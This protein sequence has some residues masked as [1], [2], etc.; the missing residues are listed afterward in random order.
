[1]NDDRELELVT[2]CPSRHPTH[3]KGD[4]S[5]DPKLELVTNFP[6]TSPELAKK[7]TPMVTASRSRF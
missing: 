7:E 3:L 5:H 1:M 4:I 2:I 6:H